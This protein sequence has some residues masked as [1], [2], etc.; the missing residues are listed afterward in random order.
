MKIRHFDA[1]PPTRTAALA[2]AAGLITLPSCE[3]GGG[4]WPPGSTADGPD[5]DVAAVERTDETTTADDT[6]SNGPHSDA[7]TQQ[8]G[9]APEPEVEG[10]LE[11]DAIELDDAPTRVTHFE[12][13][14]NGNE[15]L[16]TTK[17]GRVMH[18]A[19]DRD[20]TVLLGEFEVPDV[21]TAL[22]CGIIGA[23]ID[24]NFRDN[25][26]FYLSF[27]F[28]DQ[29]SGIVRYELNTEDYSATPE[30]G[31]EILRVGHENAE[32]AIHNV[33]KIGFDADGNMYTGVGEKAR[34]SSA[35]DPAS[36]LGTLVRF[37]PL[38]AGGYEAPEPPNPDFGLDTDI[39]LVYA[40][41]FRSPWTVIHDSRGRYWVGDVG[42]NGD[43]SYEEINVVKWDGLD[44]AWNMFEGPCPDDGCEGTIAPVRSWKRRP[45]NE[46]ELDDEGVEAVNARVAWVGLEYTEEENDRYRG[47]LH[48]RVLYGDMCLG[49]VRGVTTDDDGTLIDD[50]HLGHA[51]GVSAWQVGPDG[52]VYAATYG[53]CT[54]NEDSSS[55]PKGRLLKARFV[56]D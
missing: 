31:V 15:F 54:H 7:A 47:L 36:L 19:L 49:F 30:S 12:F 41:G 27:C 14:P 55:V 53:L 22:D 37:R 45:T 48:N 5:T 4:P 39:P 32:R 38:A 33:G 50:R 17:H 2:F 8:E 34:S 40:I 6:D 35:R 1:C 43:D 11:F 52:F 24:P 18:Y 25:Q 20:T 46:F 44:F 42:S 21:H 13:L 28:S 29:F 9:T 56:A 23:T 10:H 3:S 16:L 26:A 51:A